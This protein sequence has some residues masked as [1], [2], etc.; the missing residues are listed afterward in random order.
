MMRTSTEIGSLE[1]TRSKVISCNAQ[2][3]GLHFPGDVADLV[4]EQGAAV[5]QLEAAGPV[6]DGAGERPLDVTE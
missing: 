2:Q 5:G 1:P 4:E 6:A 3:L